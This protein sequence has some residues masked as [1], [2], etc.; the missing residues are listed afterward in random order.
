M[1]VAQ[2]AH[3]R[4]FH[5]LVTQRAGALEDHFLGRDRPLGESRVLYEIGSGGADLRELRTRLDL[6]SGYLSRLVQSLVARGLAT[7]RPALDDERVRRAELTPEGLAE[8]DE[9]NRRANVVAQGILGPLSSEQRERLVAAM[10][11]VE[12][13]LRASRVVIER[14]DPAAPDARWGVARYFEELERRFEGGFDPGRSL[15]ADDAELAP[16]RGSFLVARLDGEPIGCG[17]VKMLAPGV[18]SLKRM[19]VADAVRGLGVGRRLLAAL[20][21]EARALGI[22][23]LQLETNRAL[24]AA[25]GLYRS[26]GYIEVPAFNADPYAHHWFEK[27]LPEQLTWDVVRR[28]LLAMA[29]E[30]LRVRTELAADGSLF[31][32][33]HPRMRAVHDAHAARLA[34]ILRQQGWPGEAQVGAD[35]AGAAWLIVQ[36]AIGQPALQREA[37]EALRV[38]S[39]QGAVPAERAAMLEDRIRTLEGQPQRYG[40]QV[41]WD[42]S[43]EL[44]P[45]PMEDPD[46]VDARRREVGLGPLAEAVRALRAA[47]AAEGE[48]PPGDW[49]AR[50]RGMEEWLRE[51]GWRD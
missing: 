33:Y 6:D 11:E 19:W 42:E 46:T 4:R 7:V 34:T 21:V 41:D 40:T 48:R 20:E 26:A 50:R 45:L 10:A 35:G 17:A 2:L 16:P 13:L 12:R 44:N 37:L 30:D 22:T 14:T 47:A 15:P 9:M 23:I 43:G 27:R 8:L 1:E 32:G 38:A 18:G 49:H 39:A 29:E 25:I 31:D 51:A 5:R 3:V 28:E 24:T 36:H